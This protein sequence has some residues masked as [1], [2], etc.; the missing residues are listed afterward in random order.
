M[1][2]FVVFQQKPSIC[3]LILTLE[4][5]KTSENICFRL[6]QDKKR[7][8]VYLPEIKIFHDFLFGSLYFNM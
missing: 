4:I 3:L 8:R 1:R 5:V 7:R 2:I 6:I